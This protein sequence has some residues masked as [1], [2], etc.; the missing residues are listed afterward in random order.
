MPEFVLTPPATGTESIILDPSEV[1]DAERT[2]LDIHDGDI[3]VAKSGPDWGESA[4]QLY[5]TQQAWG[6]VVVDTWAPNRQVQIPLVVGGNNP[7]GF[8]A[9]RLALQAKVARIQAE[10][11]WLK[12]T[13]KDGKKLYLDIVRGG[14][15]LKMGGGDEQALY[16][17]DADAVL[18][19]E[20]LPDF[21]EDEI[22]SSD[23]VETTNP[24]LI[25]VEAVAKGDYPGRLTI[26]VDEDSGVDQ[27]G[28]KAALRCRHYD[29]A[30]TAALVYEAEALTALDAAAAT[31]LTGASGAGKNTIAHT[32]LGANWTPVLGTLIGGTTWMTHQGLYRLLV[33][34]YTT[35]ATP[36]DLRFIYDIGDAVNPTEN[37]QVT[38]PG[39]DNFYLMDLGEVRLDAAPVGTH[40]WQGMLQAKGAVGGENVY[41]DRVWF[42]PVDDGC[43]TLTA[44]I[45]PSIGGTTYAARDEFNQAAGNLTGKS[46]AVSPGVYAAMTNSDTTDFTVGS[47]VAQRTA[48]SD[49]GTIVAGTL[50]GRALGTGLNIGDTVAHLDISNSAVAQVEQ[51]LMVR[52]VDEKNFLLVDLAHHTASQYNLSVFKVVAGSLT[53]LASKNID[54]APT[55]DSTLTVAAIGASVLVYINAVGAPLGEPTYVLS[56]TDLSGA[57]K[58]GDID[59]YDQCINGP[60]TRTYDNFGVWTPNLD[61]VLY[62]KQSAYLRWDGN[63]RESLDGLS[64]GPVADPTGDLL[65]MPVSGEENRSVEIMVKASRGDFGLVPDSGIDDISYKLAYRPSHLFVPGV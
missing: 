28:L 51:G 58:T 63:Y 41:I 37:D 1:A 46:P 16:D 50:K 59:I 64:V 15:S 9:A 20:C 22:T 14:A 19:L 57:L 23:H 10:G 27:L 56:D 39:T 5:K 11:G 30:A 32:N 47:G 12:R 33:R 65:R 48:T 21:Y 54:V 42:W 52:V 29:S 8:S 55:S 35:S 36:P 60:C 62:A 44:P 49:S 4:L 31:A 13:L 24:E 40:R 17:I 45:D 7:V 61:A 3:L 18:T 6:E 53:A 26:T 2:E 34:V 43:V 25:A 38:I